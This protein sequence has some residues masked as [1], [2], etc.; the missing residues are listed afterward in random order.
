M[1]YRLRNSE[2]SLFFFLFFRDDKRRK[3]NSTFKSPKRYNERRKKKFDM[4]WQRL[5]HKHHYTRIYKFSYKPFKLGVCCSH[6]H[7]R[8]HTSTMHTAAKPYQRQQR[9]KRPKRQHLPNLRQYTKTE[10]EK[11]ALAT[12]AW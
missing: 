6:A 3:T 12:L 5:R 8:T 2:L 11:G 10:K 1:L 7:T 4:Q 9:A